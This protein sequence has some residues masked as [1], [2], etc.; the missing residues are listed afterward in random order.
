[1]VVRFNIFVETI[2]YFYEFLMN[3]TELIWN[4][5]FFVTN[6]KVTNLLN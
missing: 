5:F 4:C 6:V 1:M 2:I 3:R